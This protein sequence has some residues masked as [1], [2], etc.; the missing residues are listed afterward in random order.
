MLVNGGD[1]DLFIIKL[2][3]WA[4]IDQP[5]YSGLNISPYKYESQLQNMVN[6]FFHPQNITELSSYLCSF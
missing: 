6:F 5:K 2:T 4:T 1:E 3:D